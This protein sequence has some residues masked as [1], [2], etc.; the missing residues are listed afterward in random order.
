LHVNVKPA[1][2]QLHNLAVQGPLSRETLAALIWTAPTHPSLSDLKWFRFLV[3]RIGGPQGIPVIVSRTGY[4]GELGYEVFCHPADGEAVWDA[5]WAAGE[6]HGIAPLG[7]EALDLVRIEA[8]LVFAGHEF[9]DQ[10]DPFEAGIGFTVA[11]DGPEFIGQAALRERAAHP[12]RRLAGLRLEGQ[13]LARHGDELYIGRR[14]VGVVT[15]GI[16]SPGLGASIALCRIDVA[17]AE[18]GTAVEVGKLDGLRKRL[19]ATVVT[20]PFYDPGKERP[21]S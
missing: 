20:I 13:E 2:E 16:R 21:R 19:A 14:R 18:P 1:T 6:P 17:C 8:G 12:R 15:S 10:V 3:G 9:D 11:L 7:L 4:T 5:I